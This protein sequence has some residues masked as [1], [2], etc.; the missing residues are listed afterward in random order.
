MKCKIEKYQVSLEVKILKNPKSECRSIL[1]LKLRTSV[2]SCLTK[3]IT[4]LK[5]A[6][7]CKIMQ[8]YLKNLS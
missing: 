2:R 6:N 3:P 1:S 4:N 8:V 5:Y 7:V